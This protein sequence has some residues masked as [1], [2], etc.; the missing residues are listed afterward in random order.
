MEEK[1]NICGNSKGPCLGC[2]RRF[3]ACQDPKK[4]EDFKEFR[5]KIDQA[6]ENERRFKESMNTISESK[7][8]EL[9]RSKRYQRNMRNQ[10]RLSSE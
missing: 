5:K 7:K 2:T 6:R 9:W 10:N 4:C 8:R 1:K 3:E